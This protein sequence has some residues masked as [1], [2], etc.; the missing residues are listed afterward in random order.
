[1]ACCCD[2]DIICTLKRLVGQTVTIYCTCGGCSGSGFTGVVI[3]VDD[4]VVKLITRVG[5][6]PTCALGS[7]CCGPCNRN[8]GGCCLGSVTSI[9]LCNIAAVVENAI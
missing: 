6:A 9:P 5:S 8:Y 3:C 4:N 2:N 7:P 1:M